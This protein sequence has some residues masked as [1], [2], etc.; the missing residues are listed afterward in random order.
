MSPPGPGGQSLFPQSSRGRAVTSLIPERSVTVRSQGPK[1]TSK[2]SHPRHPIVMEISN[3]SHHV[4]DKL[5]FSFLK[6]FILCKEG[7]TVIQK[8]RLLQSA[9]TKGGF[10]PPLY[11]FSNLQVYKPK[12]AAH[13]HCKT[14]GKHVLLYHVSSSGLIFRLKVGP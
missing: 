5:T 8:H 14:K 11:L 13:T 10:P 7:Q 1:G 3:N 2:E 12:T 6:G 4:R 9:T